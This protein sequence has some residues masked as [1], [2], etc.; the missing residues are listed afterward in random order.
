MY[1]TKNREFNKAACGGAVI[2][3]YFKSIRFNS[4]L[5]FSNSTPSVTPGIVAVSRPENLLLTMPKC[6]CILD[7]Q[8]RQMSEMNRSQRNM[9]IQ[10]G[11]R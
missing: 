11:L 10:V 9:T 5:Y 6:T 2:A 8:K 1:F 7:E 3:L 4:R